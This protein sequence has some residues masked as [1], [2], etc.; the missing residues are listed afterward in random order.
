MNLFDFDSSLPRSIVSLLQE[1][2]D[3]LLKEIPDELPPLRGI[4]RKIDFVPRATIH[5]WSSYRTNP[6]ETVTFQFFFTFNVH[7]TLLFWVSW[8]FKPPLIF[9]I[10]RYFAL[11]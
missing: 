2:E 9:K 10:Y 11:R 5:N 8:P 7:Q 6:E 3:I 4:E 1:F